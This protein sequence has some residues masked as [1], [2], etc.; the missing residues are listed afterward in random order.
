MTEERI[1]MSAPTKKRSLAVLVT[2][3]SLFQGCVYVPHATE[4]YDAD[5]RMV[6]KRLVLKAEQVGAL[7][8]C[9]GDQCLGELVGLGII[10]GGSLVVSGSVVLVGNVLYWIEEQGRCR[11][12]AIGTK[13]SAAG[14]E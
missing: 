7:G 4:G 12:P 5:C 9:N 13:G 14:P 11:A 3:V 10:A 1:G 6:T 2:T 8:P